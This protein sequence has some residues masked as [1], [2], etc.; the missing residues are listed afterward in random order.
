M[1]TCIKFGIMVLIFPVQLISKLRM[2]NCLS[3]CMAMKWRRKGRWKEVKGGPRN[4]RK[5]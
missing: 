3:I 5:F 1:K 4:S 2:G